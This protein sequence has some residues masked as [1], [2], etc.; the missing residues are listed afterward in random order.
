MASVNEFIQN[1]SVGARANL[2]QLEIAGFDEKLKFVAKAAQVPGKAI[3]PIEVR[4]LSHIIKV[5][6]DPVF[7][8][9]TATILHD[10]DHGI[11]TALDDWQASIVANDDA[12]A[13][14]ALTDYFREITISQLK[15]D[16]TVNE[17]GVYKLQNAW[18]STI[19]PMDLGFENADTILEYGVTFS[20]SHWIKGS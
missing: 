19:E 17:A 8:D 4:Y 14:G 10:E 11:R 18:P 2:Y 1:F 15:S 9:W 3:G 5:A 13:A 20:Y 6:G 16:G 12:V 7:D